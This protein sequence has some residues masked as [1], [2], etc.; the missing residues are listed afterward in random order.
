MRRL[1][2]AVASIEEAWESGDPSR[3][4]VPGSADHWMLVRQYLEASWL[5]GRDHAN[6]EIAAQNDGEEFSAPTPESRG[7]I[8]RDAIEWML[9]R[10]ELAGKWDRQLDDL[11][12]ATVAEGM[13]SGAT[14]KESIA[15]LRVIFP[16]FSKHRLENIARTE[17]SAAYTQGRLAVFLDPRN[18]CAALQFAA[19][20][21]NRTTDICRSRDGLIMLID[22]PRLAANT[23]PLHYQCRSILSP[24]TRSTWERLLAGDE[25]ALKSAFGWVPEGGPKTVEEALAGWDKAAPP[26]PGFGGTDPAPKRAPYQPVFPRPQQGANAVARELVDER[27]VELSRAVWEQSDIRDK[28]FF[29]GRL[30]RVE[31]TVVRSLSNFPPTL[32]REL[33]AASDAGLRIQL[34]DRLPLNKMGIY[35]RAERR[36]S[37]T[38]DALSSETGVFEEE[39]V[40]ALDHWLGSRGTDLLGVFSAGV[41]ARSSLQ[42]A[43]DELQDLYRNPANFLGQYQNSNSREFLAGAVRFWLTDKEILRELYPAVFAW[44]ES[45]WFSEEFWKSVL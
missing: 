18:G 43:A 33:E 19:I 8:P 4:R 22:D 34:A 11:V 1:A 20:L 14:L 3:A 35:S 42:R 39:L 23:P 7:P 30:K 13:R 21:D 26:L 12:Q 24:L 29:G 5:W 36:I 44:L 9:S 16:D 31:A 6:T 41:V 28:E 15:A 17:S 37:F 45:R 40:H 25:Q 10:Q 27:R 38:L 2:D 32:L